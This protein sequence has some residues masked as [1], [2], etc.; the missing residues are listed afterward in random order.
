MSNYT[1]AGVTYQVNTFTANGTLNVTREGVAD[2]LIIGGGGSGAIGYAGGGGGAGGHKEVSGVLPAGSLDITVGAG[3]AAAVL[4]CC[5]P[6]KTGNERYRFFRGW[7]VLFSR[8]WWRI[9]I[10]CELD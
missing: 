7:S 4:K 5:I 2:M 10:W 3:G 6:S 8:W 1:E 9:F